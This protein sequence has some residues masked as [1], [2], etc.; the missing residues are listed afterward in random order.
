MNEPIGL[1]YQRVVIAIEVNDI[2]SDRVLSPEFE[3]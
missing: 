3:A 2:S 1:Y